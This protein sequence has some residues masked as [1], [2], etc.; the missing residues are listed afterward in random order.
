MSKNSQLQNLEAFKA[1]LFQF[2][3]TRKYAVRKK[4]KDDDD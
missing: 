2:N 3:R 1:W 4:R